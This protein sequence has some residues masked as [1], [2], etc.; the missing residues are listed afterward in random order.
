MKHVWRNVCL[1]LA[2]LLLLLTVALAADSG[3]NP[4]GLRILEEKETISV[5][6]IPPDSDEIMTY[7]DVCKIGTMTWDH[8]D[9]A[10]AYAIAITKDGGETMHDTASQNVFVLNGKIRESGSY[11]LCVA[12]LDAQGEEISGKSAA[13]SWTYTMPGSLPTP[14]ITVEGAI[15]TVSCSSSLVDYYEIEFFQGG[16]YLGNTTTEPESPQFSMPQWVYEQVQGDNAVT[17]CAFARTAN[18]LEA[19]DSP[20]SAPVEIALPQEMAPVE[21]VRI[22]TQEETHRY[23]D[24]LGQEQTITLGPGCVVWN[25]RDKD[26]HYDV[27]YY[28]VGQD[29]EPELIHETGLGMPYFSLDM[30]DA[31]LTSGTYYAV[32]REIAYELGYVASAWQQTDPWTYTQAAPL[33]TP[34]N[35]RW[36]GTVMYCDPVEGAD[37]YA[38]RVYYRASDEEEFQ[39][40][41]AT[42]VNTSPGSDAGSIMSEWGDG[43]YRFTVS[44]VS[45]NI[46]EAVSSPY[47]AMGPS[48]LRSAQP[49]PAP[50]GFRIVTQEET[51][52]YEFEG[53]S[54]TDTLY[55]GYL[56]WE[57][58]PNATSYFLEVYREGASYPTC[59]YSERQGPFCDLF[60]FGRELQEGTYTIQL[61][62]AD[63]MGMYAASEPVSL[64]YDYHPQGRL[65]TPAIT[66]SV[67]EDAN[68]MI[69]ISPV[70][71]E[72]ER[73]AGYCLVLHVVSED[74]DQDFTYYTDQPSFVL[75]KHTISYYQGSTFTI[76]VQA[77][78]NDQFTYRN[79]AIS[80]PYPIELPALSEPENL[81][82]VTEANDQLPVGTIQFT[83][84]AVTEGNY[85][86]EVYRGDHTLVGSYQMSGA[87]TPGETYSFAGHLYD[88]PE[89]GWYYY[90]VTSLTSVD[91]PYSQ[92][93]TVRSPLWQY[94]PPEKYTAVS[95]A[96]WQ[97]DAAT[98]QYPAG[99]FRADGLLLEV[100]AGL[101]ADNLD[102]KAN[103][104]LIRDLQM[105][106]E[107]IE[108]D[109][110]YPD[111]DAFFVSFRVR[112]ISS[113]L[114]RA[115]HG[116]WVWAETVRVQRSDIETAQDIA[117]LKNQETLGD[118]QTALLQ[119]KVEDKLSAWEAV[120][121][122]MRET[123]TALEQ[124]VNVDVTVQDEENNPSN[125]Q[126]VGLGLSAVN[127][128]APVTLTVTQEPRLKL[129]DAPAI[130]GENFQ[131]ATNVAFSATNV[132]SELVI[133]V[134]ISLPVSTDNPDQLRLY[135]GDDLEEVPFTLT[136]G[137]VRFAVSDLSQT[138]VLAEANPLGE[139]T[140]DHDGTVTVT[141][142]A[143]D[144]A[145]LYAASYNEDG[146]MLAVATDTIA[147]GKTSYILSLTPGAA[148]QVFL[149]DENQ[150]PLCQAKII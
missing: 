108:M 37:G 61:K 88:L 146:K 101:E 78:S 136:N 35:L 142:N 20:L 111:Y 3:D 115:A 118:M 79:S 114:S 47:S 50:T 138:Y 126:V 73:I 15:G 98:W 99:S 134:Q 32:V 123:V 1:L 145:I 40:V 71:G 147:A 113:D 17:C 24:W 102:W 54:Y 68:I 22:L 18:M 44:A 55:P 30:L 56:T 58:D 16:E 112:L 100:W 91:S 36:E 23:I 60:Q 31:D 62:A 139:V 96:T 45:N 149:L 103:T 9:G 130:T 135:K 76:T 97:G 85:L 150:M 107:T 122:T 137:R 84:G 52:T 10:K 2:V 77:L 25:Q 90:T 53:D 133:P 119:M 127:A 109:S 93:K 8:V 6:F 131:S 83:E 39:W 141:A 65:S 28:R 63:I 143:P 66:A 69:S 89:P 67:T 75:P 104:V 7:Q 105:D 121:E 80:Q 13:I 59:S 87:S 43:E 41:H 72:A 95:S 27:A 64:T 94:D 129:L 81:T 51:V 29:G 46:A 26:S 92:S 144:G 70:E 117:A 34:T 128:S 82:W 116:D 148:V 4:I 110:W 74:G 125:V 57:W 48:L 12:A 14:S 5:T 140:V 106:R 19:S 38:F 11:Q 132:K 124:K 120:P 42:N 86:V 49:L 33:D 21:G